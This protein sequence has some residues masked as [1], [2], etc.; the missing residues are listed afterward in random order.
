MQPALADIPALTDIPETAPAR[1]YT[2]T[3]PA[4]LAS[5]AEAA[6]L[7]QDSD[8]EMAALQRSRARIFEDFGQSPLPDD[9][10]LP[11]ALPAEFL[12]PPPAST[13]PDRVS[14]AKRPRKQRS[15]PSATPPRLDD[16]LG[17]LS[18][19]PAADT[20]VHARAKAKAQAKAKSAMKKRLAAAAEG[21]AL[22]PP[23]KRPAAAA[24]PLPAAAAVPAL[25]AA[26]VG[27]DDAVEVI[28]VRC[29]PALDIAVL[30]QCVD[31]C[32]A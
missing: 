11:P 20:N 27:D 15:L 19:V 25:P 30:K 12:T 18:K 29:A 8:G 4:D 28:A 31:H 21:P 13:A 14:T 2:T 16:V 23:L 10:D 3:E 9:S 26:S 22:V 1:S 5:L 24:A 32:P 6:A 7:V 17:Q